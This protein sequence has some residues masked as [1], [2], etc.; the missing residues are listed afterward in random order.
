M[1]PKPPKIGVGGPV[2]SGKTALVEWLCRK[3]H[4]LLERVAGRN[5]QEFP[6]IMF[7]EEVVHAA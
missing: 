6:I 3:L 4:G 2:G 1:I 7:C 5:V